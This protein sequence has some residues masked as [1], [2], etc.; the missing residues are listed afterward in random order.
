MNAKDWRHKR[1][2]SPWG[3]A[4]DTSG[5]RKQP[6]KSHLLLRRKRIKEEIMTAMM[7][8]MRMT[9]V[10]TQRKILTKMMKT[11]TKMKQRSRKRRK[12]SR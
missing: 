9:T 11:Q 5:V 3:M 8:V 7:T 12:S 6:V 1:G 4:S 2:N 10:I